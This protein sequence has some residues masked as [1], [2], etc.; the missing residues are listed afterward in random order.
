MKI[1]DLFGKTGVYGSSKSE[2]AKKVEERENE[3]ARSQVG[4]DDDRTTISTKAKL[5]AQ[6]AEIRDDDDSVQ[7]NR[8]AELKR[9]IEAGDYN[10]SSRNVAEKINDFFSGR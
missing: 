3:N 10:I 2:S 7:S 4:S 9:R 8:V 1:S 5:L 6:I